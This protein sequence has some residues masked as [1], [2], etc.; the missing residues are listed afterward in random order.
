[1]AAKNEC[2]KCGGAMSEGFVIDHGDYQVKQ[3][4]IWVE[5]EPQASF[6]SGLKTSGKQAYN[7]R[8]FRCENCNFLEFY[9]AEEADLSGLFN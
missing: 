7:V 6:W 9:T 2:A 4:Q 1:M 5:G 8:A 3:Q